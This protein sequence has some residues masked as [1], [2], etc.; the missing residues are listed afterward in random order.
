MKALKSI[1]ASKVLADPQAREGLRRFIIAA[2]VG[3]AAAREGD[4][5]AYIRLGSSGETMKAEFVPKA[6]AV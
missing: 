4:A 2:R 6:K 5:H 1:L 3:A